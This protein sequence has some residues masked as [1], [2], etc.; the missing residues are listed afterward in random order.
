MSAKGRGRALH[1]PTDFTVVS[2]LWSGPGQRG[3][4][5]IAFAPHHH[6][7][8]NISA[9]N[10]CLLCARHWAVAEE[11]VMSKSDPLSVSP[12][13]GSGAGNEGQCSPVVP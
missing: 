10:H 7:S 2:M 5:P 6:H 4:R 1:N 3:G 8:Q 12:V 9:P 13:P 11:M